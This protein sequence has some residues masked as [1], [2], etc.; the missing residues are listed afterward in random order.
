MP[1]R[2]ASLA[3]IAHWLAQQEEEYLAPPAIEPPLPPRLW[4]PWPGNLIGTLV[5]TC[6]LVLASINASE[7]YWAYS[8]WVNNLVRTLSALQLLWLFVAWWHDYRAMKRYRAVLAC[9]A[10]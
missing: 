2:A 3:R 5:A 6:L 1:D 8:L 4:Y 10:E 9:T 7:R